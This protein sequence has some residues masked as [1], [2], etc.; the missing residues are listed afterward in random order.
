MIGGRR[1]AA[2]WL[3]EKLS[4]VT[5]SGEFIPEIDGFRFIAILAVVS[6]HLMA[7]YLVDTERFGPH[8]PRNWSRVDDQSMLVQLAFLGYFGVQLFFVI[9]GFILV[10]PFARSYLGSGLARPSLKS[11]YLRRLTRIEPPYVINIVLFSLYIWIRQPGQQALVPHV[12]ASLLYSHNLVYGEASSINEL[13]W[14]LEIEVQFYLLVP[15]LATVFAI[16]NATARRAVLVAATVGLGI[17]PQWWI[18][19]DGDPRLYLTVLSVLQ[20]FLAGF[21]LADLYLTVS[22]KDRV[23]ARSWDVV[24]ALSG[25]TGL[26]VLSRF[27]D[28]SFSLPFVVALGYL[29]MFL[30]RS[31]NAIIRFRPV[32]VV[33]GMCYTIYLYHGM[34]IGQMSGRVIRVSTFAEPFWLEFLVYALLQCVVILTVSAVLFAYTEKPFM[35]RWR[36]FRA[37]LRPLVKDGGA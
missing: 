11:Y 17:V 28:L 10:L 37:L 31:A 1:S 35:R 29:G 4:R 33:G 5:S 23:P 12:I 21:I 15:L 27:P 2:D 19:H 34:I 25:L 8:L 3:A 13:A 16:R 20:Y 7:Q 18:A 30:G 9:S 6:H 14:S 24:V 26:V 22:V 36:G 32:V